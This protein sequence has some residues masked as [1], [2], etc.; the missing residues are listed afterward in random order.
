M[1]Y[2]LIVTPDELKS[3]TVLHDVID[4]LVSNINIA[5]EAS[6]MRTSSAHISEYL[7]ALARLVINDNVAQYI[8]SKCK[9]NATIDGF[10][11][12]QELFL[13][14]ND[15]TADD[16]YLKYLS[17]IALFNIFSSFSYQ[18]IA[19]PILA[20][21]KK[22]VEIVKKA[23]HY[24]NEQDVVIHPSLLQHL[25]SIKQAAEAILI[26]LDLYQDED[27]TSTLVRSK[28]AHPHVMISYSHKD[29]AFCRDLVR[30]LKSHAINVWVDEDGH[31]RSDDCWE[32][33]ARAIKYASFILVIVSPSYCQSPSCRKEA[34]YADKRK[35]P[36]IALYPNSDK[37]EPDEWLDIRLTGTYV[38]F[39]GNGKK[40]FDDCIVRLLE[41]IQPQDGASVKAN[42]PE[43]TSSLLPP[44]EHS[45][46]MPVSNAKPIDILSSVPTESLTKTKS[47]IHDW[48]KQDVETWFLIERQLLPELYQMY[49]F[50]DGDSLF[51]YAKYFLQEH[52]HD[53][54]QQYEKLQKRLR[55]QSGVELY[56]NNYTDFVC[57]MKKLLLAYKTTK[58]MQK[59][60]SACLIV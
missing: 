58:T 40:S 9:I 4:Y 26:N 36:L 32:E 16:L 24:Q 25:S 42:V 18:T 21:N 15:L 30:A 51:E 10:I 43:Q 11:F 7:I 46:H 33:I 5:S 13:K 27:T 45:H 54:K 12:F 57:S 1:A 49:S 35:Q 29:I 6:D 52:E 19:Q 41:Y 44:P 47:S 60:S 31:C 22:F 3:T 55:D 14:Y 8:I 38:R 17:R 48:T 53:A 34:T 2:A 56:D 23:S 50:V 28:T 20:S 39:G 37:Y 59:G